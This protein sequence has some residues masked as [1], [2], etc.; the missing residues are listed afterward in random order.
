MVIDLKIISLES[1]FNELSELGFYS[2]YEVFV[3]SKD[4]LWVGDSY[5]GAL[6]YNKDEDVFYTDSAT[7]K[8][9]NRLSIRKY[10]GILLKIVMGKFGLLEVHQVCSGLMNQVKCF[11]LLK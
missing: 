2:T 8:R 7:I 11:V 4:R 5:H 3:D 9:F 10:M 6:L 1:L